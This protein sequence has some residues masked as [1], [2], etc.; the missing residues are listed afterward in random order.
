MSTTKKRS[1][2]VKDAFQSIKAPK[3]SSSRKAAKLA[4]SKATTTSKS[5]PS[6]T[7]PTTTTPK[8]NVVADNYK[9]RTYDQPVAIFKHVGYTPQHEAERQ[10]SPGSSAATQLLTPHAIALEISAKA[11]KTRA[12]K[13]ILSNFEVPE[14]FERPIRFGPISG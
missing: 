2:S 5:G 11:A 12:A 6:K 3:R 10:Y 1:R 7:K 13:F 9:V 4:P 14:D 8:E